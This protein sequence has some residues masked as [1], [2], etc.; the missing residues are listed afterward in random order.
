[1]SE[2][3]NQIVGN[4]GTI[5]NESNLKDMTLSINSCTTLQPAQKDE[6]AGL[7]KELEVVLQPIAVSH[8]EDYKRITK[9]LDLGVGEATSAKPDREFLKVTAEGLKA[10]ASSLK[11]VAPAVLVVAGKVVQ[12]LVGLGA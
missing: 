10:A 2:I 4:S 6:L 9:T 7:V 8:P 11:D 3:K 12:F 5:I 1:M